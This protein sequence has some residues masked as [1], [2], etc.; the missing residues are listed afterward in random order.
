MKNKFNLVDSIIL[1]ANKT[2]NKNDT[3]PFDFSE[4]ENTETTLEDIFKPITKITFVLKCG[5][6][7]VT[8]CTRPPYAFYDYYNKCGKKL[9]ELADANTIYQINKNDIAYFEAKPIIK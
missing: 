9:V 7:I 3:N 1:P 6:E 8:T 4:D 5:K 2:I